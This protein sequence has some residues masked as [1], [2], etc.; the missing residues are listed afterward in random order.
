ME[1]HHT[2]TGFIW[3]R[4]GALPLVAAAHRLTDTLPEADFVWERRSLAEFA[5]FQID[6]RDRKRLA[7]A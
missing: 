4:R 2:R 5:D 7:Y 6:H 3:N 1:E